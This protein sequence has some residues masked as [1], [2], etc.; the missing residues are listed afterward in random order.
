MTDGAYASVQ[1]LF[2]EDLK[3]RVHTPSYVVRHHFCTISAQ[4]WCLH[5]PF[6]F[7]GRRIATP[8][9]CFPYIDHHSV[10]SLVTCCLTC[11]FHVGIRERGKLPQYLS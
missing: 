9:P 8:P 2:E 10:P 7:V 4:L 1:S 3:P 5:E 11:L 6:R